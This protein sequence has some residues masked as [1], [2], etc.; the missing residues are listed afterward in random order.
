MPSNSTKTALVIVFNHRYDKNIKPLKEIYSSRF[1]NIYF[2]VPF[3]D[4]NESNVIPVYGNSYYYSTYLAQAARFFCDDAYTHYFFV[5]DDMI[6]NPE[7]NEHNLLEILN[8]EADHCFIPEIKCLHEVD[9]RWNVDY[10]MQFNIKTWGIEASKELPTYDEALQHFTRH[11]IEIKPLSEAQAFEPE[12]MQQ[13]AKRLAK[14]AMGKAEK[15]KDNY[16][17]PYPQ[18]T[19]LSDILLVSKQAIKKFTHY[20]G[21]FGSLGLFVE[22]AIPTALV[23]SAAS[24][25][26]E[27]DLKLQGRYLWTMDELS[28]LDKYDYDLA[29]LL[30]DFPK[31]YLFI[32]PVKISKWNTL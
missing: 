4:G 16:Q 28:V 20:C 12:T 6:L 25:R 24:I 7:V 22:L 1:S 8:C 29:K 26:F 15:R 5:A 17:L 32:H 18:V 9:D 21:V 14:V 19:G 10:A 27:K 30:S 2:V 31:G 23:L 13:K 3:Y 11:N